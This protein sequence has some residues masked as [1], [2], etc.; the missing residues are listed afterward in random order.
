MGRFAVSSG[1]MI[2]V[3]SWTAFVGAQTAPTATASA[4]APA[5]APPGSVAIAPAPA[6]TPSASGAMQA[7]VITAPSVGPPS[8]PPPEFAPGYPPPPGYGPAYYPPPYGYGGYYGPPPPMHLNRPHVHD[9]LYLRLGLGI[10]RLGA[11]FTTDESADFGGS[12]DGSVANVSGVFE[13][14]VGGTPAPGLV[15][16][17][18]LWFD[19]TGR[20]AT[21]DLKV[22]GTPTQNL[23]FDGVDLGLV[24][25]FVD[26]YI[27]PR[28]GFHVQA[29]LGVAIVTVGR[30]DDGPHS[31]DQTL[32]GLGFMLGTG[33][34]WWVADQWSM[35]AIVRLLYGT[36]ESGRDEYEQWNYKVL[37]IPEIAFVATYH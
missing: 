5:A 8:G 37:A 3:V 13:V 21:H 19:G 30:G 7:G 22:N 20:H 17:G 27:N 31:Y 15:L 26:Y 9:G 25:P 35:G 23:R 6:A 24:G 36:V 14:A 10:G 16:G 12:V 11:H 2:V 1:A 18:G 29:A 34:E 28:L 33:Y 32:G 4:T